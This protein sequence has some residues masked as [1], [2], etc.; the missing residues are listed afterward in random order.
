M[1]TS[2]LET[3]ARKYNLTIE[4]TIERIT[5]LRHR[6]QS[7]NIPADDMTELEVI[8]KASECFNP[9]ICRQ[10]VERNIQRNCSELIGQLSMSESFM[11]EFPELLWRR[12]YIEALED[13][14][15]I[16]TID[17]DRYY[18]PN[19]YDGDDVE[20][21]CDLIADEADA[22]QA[23]D[24]AGIDPIESEVYEY[25]ILSDS[26][27]MGA[28]EACGECVADVYGLPVWGRC[29]TGQSIAMDG[30]IL[31]VCRDQGILIGQPFQW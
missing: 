5:D 12:N 16:Q 30:V 6:L 13:A 10:W 1:K 9:D 18:V 14:E 4:Q 27:A 3:I 23:C 28:L 20:N 19:W 31:E 11:D 26:H 7:A 15:L 24:D 8:D 21:D 17:G 29:T 22:Q 2:T 25:W